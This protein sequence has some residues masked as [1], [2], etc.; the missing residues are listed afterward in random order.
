[1][2]TASLSR[3]RDLVHFGDW[4]LKADAFLQGPHFKVQAPTT[5]ERVVSSQS[6]LTDCITIRAN[7]EM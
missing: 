7:F 6:R 4:I 5:L 2:P 3:S 1:M